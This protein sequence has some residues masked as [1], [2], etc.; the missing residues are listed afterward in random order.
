ML[1][2]GYYY[3][4]PYGQELLNTFGATAEPLVHIA[5]TLHGY[6]AL[7]GRGKVAEKPYIGR[8]NDKSRR[9]GDR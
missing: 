6:I 4:P 2:A 5:V 8:D 9:T 1:Y 7:A 3:E